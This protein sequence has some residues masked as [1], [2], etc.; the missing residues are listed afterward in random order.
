M[1]GSNIIFVTIVKAPHK[2]ILD[3]SDNEFY[4]DGTGVSSATYV[5]KMYAW[6]IYNDSNST[7]W[8]CKLI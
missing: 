7:E 2:I 4:V 6:S 5:P 8:Y 1:P 3:D